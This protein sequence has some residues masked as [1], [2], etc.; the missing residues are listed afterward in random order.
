M[1]YEDLIFNVVFCRI[2]VY[3]TKLTRSLFDGQSVSQLACRDREGRC[4]CLWRYFLHTAL[5]SQWKQ[6]EGDRILN[7]QKPV[8]RDELWTVENEREQQHRC[9]LYPPTY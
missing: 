2:S 1:N 9:T 8:H 5:F 4:R 3:A 7:L 6:D